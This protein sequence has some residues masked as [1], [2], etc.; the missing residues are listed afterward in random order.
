MTT[1][2]MTPVS[3]AN[4]GGPQSE[5]HL[6]VKRGP[7]LLEKSHDSQWPWTRYLYALDQLTGTTSPENP[8]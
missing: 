7:A 4:I 1:E 8:T 6:E 5:V 2:V 3:K